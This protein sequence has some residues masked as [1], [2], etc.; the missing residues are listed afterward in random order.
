[1]KNAHLK[2]AFRP[3]VAAAVVLLSSFHTGACG[4][5]PAT[6]T[7]ED[8][9]VEVFSEPPAYR[10]LA[11]GP[12]TTHRRTMQIGG[13]ER[14]YLVSTP[15]DVYALEGLPLILVFHGYRMT[16]DQMRA[17]TDFDSAHAIVVYMQG[18]DTAWAP[19]PYATTTG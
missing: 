7:V 17:T 15:T 13:H 6:Q 9:V 19:A 2:T 11:N 4:L 12:T 5:L 10:P 18:V 1:M 8:K 3:A 16:M 14:E